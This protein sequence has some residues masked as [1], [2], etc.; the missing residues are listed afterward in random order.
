MNCILANRVPI[1][2]WLSVLTIL[3]SCK[4]TK[5]TFLNRNYHSTATRYN[6]YYN[7]TLNYNAGVSNLQEQHKDDFNQ[8]LSVYPLG[9]KKEA[10]AI[11]PQMDKALKKCASA[12][13]KHGMLIKGTEYNRWIDDSYLLIG[14]AYFYKQEY[15]K[16]IEAFRLVSRQFMGDV[17]GYEAQLWLLR[18]YVEVADFSSADL[19]IENIVMDDAFPDKLNQPLSLALANYYIK[20]NDAIM[21]IEEL[22]TAIPLTKKKRPKARYTYLLAQLYSQQDDFASSTALFTKVIRTSPDYEMV[23][24][25]KINR[26]RSYDTS[27]GGT[28]EIVKELESMLKDDKNAEYLDV[29]Y[30]GLA[31]L[32]SRQN[33]MPQAIEYYTLSVSN[34][35]KNDAQKSLSSVIL[36]DL[37]YQQQNYRLAQAYYDTTVAFMNS[38]H[39]RYKPALAKQK[40]LTDLVSNLNIIS[41]Q[42]SLQAVALMPQNERMALIDQLIEQIKLEEKKQQELENQRRSEDRFFNDPMQRNNKFN[43]NQGGA[44]YFENPNTL[45]FGFSEFNRKWG[46]RKLEDNWRRS[47]KQSLLVEEAL[48]DSLEQSVFDPKSRDSYLQGLPLTV[49][50]MKASNRMIIEAYFDAGVIY[51]EQLNDVPQAIQ[52]FETLNSRFPNNENRVMVLYF[53]TRLHTENG[54]DDIA[55]TYKEQLLSQYPNS[56][57]AKLLQDATYM[58]QLNEAYSSIENTYQQALNL[59]NEAQYQ[60]SLRVC[61]SAMASHPN[62]PL[63]PRFDLLKTM[64]QASG[65]NKD[66][67]IAKLESISQKYPSHEVA[68][69]AQELIALLKTEEVAVQK[70]AEQGDSPYIFKDNVS[71]YFILLFYDYDLEVATAKSTLSDYHAEYYRLDRLNIS[72]LLFAEHTHMLSVREFSDKAAA[73]NYYNAFQDGDVRGVF[74]DDYQAFVIA[75][76]N[77]PYFFKNKDIDG[78]QKVFKEHYQ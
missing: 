72:N 39:L 30:F 29:I 62:H 78:Y 76:P 22:K 44:W 45:S 53:L 12:I 33:K 13:S 32:S 59:Y 18:S 21:A 77:F 10:Q 37:Y 9:T 19:V 25:A 57:Y 28:E 5:N 52:S 36:A 42:D 16:A 74:G 73:M 40:T 47:N 17:T 69:T 66:S 1:F 51:K 60:A 54:Q 49:D 48:A 56:D 27:S 34:S 70:G 65:A 71:H 8:L 46:K 3:S 2:L 6:W 43:T 41:E 63:I 75:G 7:A 26:A 11:A 24:N 15:I 67:Y 61:N 55:N 23:F 38:K 20:S 68:Q 58:D 35:V 14:K 50:A 31:E 4:T 64:A